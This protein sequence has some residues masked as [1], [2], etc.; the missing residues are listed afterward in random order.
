MSA[1]PDTIPTMATDT[2]L[3]PRDRAI[4][5]FER[6]R[7]KYHGAKDTAVLHLFGLS[8]PAYI[9]ALHVIL[10]QAAARAYD[11]ELVGRLLRLR[12]ARRRDRSA[13]VVGF[14]IT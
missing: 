1:H 11:P 4:L 14:K 8:W 13:R 6:T 7:W 5:E 2:A 12:E 3:A 10:D 9:Q